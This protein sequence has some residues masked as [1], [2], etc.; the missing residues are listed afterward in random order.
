MRVPRAEGA[1]ILVDARDGAPPARL[2]G[3]TDG[4]R[5]SGAVLGRVGIQL[6]VLMP[7]KGFL[8]HVAADNSV[9]GA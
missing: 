9:A 2:R 1:C 5:A 6:P 4:F 8:L 7:G 3:T